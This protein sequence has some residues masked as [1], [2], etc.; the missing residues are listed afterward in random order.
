[1]KNIIRKT[2]KTVRTPGSLLARLLA[3]RRNVLLVLP[4]CYAPFSTDVP[5]TV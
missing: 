5:D 1:M 2:K 3:V 4:V